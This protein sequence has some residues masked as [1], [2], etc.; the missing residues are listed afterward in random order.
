MVFALVGCAA[1]LCTLYAVLGACAWWTTRRSTRAN[2]ARRH[3]DSAFWRLAARRGACIVAQG[4]DP[5]ADVP[6]PQGCD[7]KRQLQPQHEAA[8]QRLPR[9]LLD[10][11]ELPATAP[12]VPICGAQ[13]RNT[14]AVLAAGR[15][16]RP[17]T[18]TNVACVALRAQAAVNHV[19][20]SP[21]GDL[22]ASASM[23]RTV[24]LWTPTVYVLV[25]THRGCA[26]PV[27]AACTATG[28]PSCALVGLCACL[29]AKGRVP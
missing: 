18:A 14:R 5:R 9:L 24:R 28:S 13:G 2:H 16:R 3:I 12:G 19:Q 26:L 15:R 7:H 23:D 27:V 29:P 6:G 1:T 10:G 17:L 25:N 11:V 20:F 4:P 22:I 21:R 8:R